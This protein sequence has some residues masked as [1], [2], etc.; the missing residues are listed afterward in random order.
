MPVQITGAARHPQTIAV[1]AYTPLS[2]ILPLV[3]GIQNDGSF[4]NITMISSS[5]EI[6]EIDLYSLLRGS[7]KFD[8]PLIQSATRIHINDIGLTVAVSGFVGRPG[9]FELPKKN[10][11]NK[12]NRTFRTS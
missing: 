8:D 6:K 5:S 3:G 9:I 10:K 7:R 4:R 12:G 11:S 1:P 2:R